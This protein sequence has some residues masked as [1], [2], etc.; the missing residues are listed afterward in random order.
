M[1]LRLAGVFVGALLAWVFMPRGVRAQQSQEGLGKASQNPV[2]D[3][4]SIRDPALSRGS[5]ASRKRRGP[6]VIGHWSNIV[7]LVAG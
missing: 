5:S 4:T 2:G 7:P 6:A 3:L 1:R